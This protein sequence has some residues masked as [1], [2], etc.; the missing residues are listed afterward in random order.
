MAKIVCP[1][2]DCRMVSDLPDQYLGRQVA[3]KHCKKVFVATAVG[4]GP[5]PSEIKTMLV[6]DPPAGAAES[7][8]ASRGGTVE[9][10]CPTCGAVFNLKEDFLGKKVRCKKCE[11]VFTVGGEARA[12]ERA[13]S[14]SVQA[15]GGAAPKRSARDDD[16]DDRPSRKKSRAGRDDDDDD[17]RSGSKRNKRVYHDDD[18]DDD[19]DRKPV[20]KKSGGGVGMTLA[21]VGGVVLVLLLLCGGGVWGIYRFTAGVADAVDQAQQDMAN[22]AQMGPNAAVWGLEKQPGDLAE[23]LTNLKSN[24]ANERRGAANFLANQPLDGGRQKEVAAGLE[25]LVKD[26]DDNTCAAGAKAMKVWGTNANGPALTT[27]LRSRLPGGNRPFLGEDQKQL[28]GAIAAVKYEPGAEVIVEFLPNAFSGGEAEV[29]LG[30][31]GAGAERAVVKCYNH[32]DGNVR[33]KARGLCTRYGTKPAVILDQTVTDLGAIEQE[34][35]KA[36]AEWLSTP[37]SDQAQQLANAEPARRTAVAKGL[38]HLIDAPPP[39]FEDTLLRAVKRWGTKDNVASLVHMLE[40]SPFK[41]REAADALIGIGPACEP[42]VRKLLDHADGGVREQ[43][44]RILKSVS[45]PG[46]AGDIE[47]TEALADLKSGDFRRVSNAGNYL[48]RARVDEKQRPVVVAALLDALKGSGVQKGDGQIEPAAK[49]LTVWATKDDGPAVAL[50]M[51]DMDK[52]FGQ[53]SR[54]VLMEWLGTHKVDKAIPTLV[55]ALSNASDRSTASKALQ[56][57]GPDLG[58]QIEVEVVKVNAGAEKQLLL[59]LIKVLGAVGTKKGSIPALTQIDADARKRNDRQVSTAC[60]QAA[61]SINARG[62]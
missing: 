10:L 23:A 9:A 27:A 57:M 33:G 35:I 24:D 1:N 7:A 25:A 34:R 55:E 37:A 39:F 43:A 15:R 6:T 21:I 52:F 42:E 30:N 40:T 18:D 16:D 17:D 11:H 5:K 36:A 41:K 61:A 32:Q 56:T 26:S 19:F 20:R 12:K 44:K 62:K 48:Q 22:N 14:Q 38:N 47:I 54:R 2:P 4:G 50:A 53:R 28:M 3:C 46:G 31:F 13:E 29:A 49:A 59:E 51:S 60:V 45:G 58:E 8:S